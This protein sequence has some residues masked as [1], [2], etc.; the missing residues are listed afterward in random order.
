[1]TLSYDYLYDAVTAHAVGLRSRLELEPLGGPGDKIF[2]PTYSTPEAAETQ[3]AVE[4]RTLVGADG[5]V[6]VR[7]IVLDSVASQA[8]HLELAALEAVR[9]GSLA[10][11]VTS[12]DFAGRGLFGID[13][14]SDYEA[15]HRIFDAI[16]RDSFDGDDLFRHGATGRAITEATSRNA[17]ALLH[18]SPHTLVFG[19]WDSTG[20]KGG[21]GAKYER[22]LTSEI[23]AHGVRCG[24]KTASRID[25][26]GVELKAGP[27]YESADVLG[28][29]LDEHSAVQEK[30]N[31]A[32]LY[33]RGGERPGRPSNLNHG[34]VTPSI[35]SRAGGITAAEIIGTTVL[36]FIQLRRLRF[37]TSVTGDVIPADQRAAAEGAART[38]LAALG[39]AA[40]VLGY[41][42]GFDLRSR[43]VLVPRS[44]LTFELVGRAGA[45]ETVEVN[46]AAAL[47]L[48]TEAAQRAHALQLGWRASEMVLRPSERLVELI[49]RSQDVAA[50]GGGES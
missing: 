49:R 12:V 10:A 36:S 42:Q 28:W 20:P 7:S 17:S 14:I 48:V 33:S 19:G 11:P 35:N 15:P 21:R 44:K 8:N 32:K 41:E 26:L 29:T 39:L 50:T 18:H 3:Y 27:V 30:G 9:S 25:P 24:V 2:P 22:A 4:D 1:M 47:E 46:S 40:I 13:R 5:P 31:K 6:T 16:L 34:N 43:C 23:V 45:V 38:A 37:P